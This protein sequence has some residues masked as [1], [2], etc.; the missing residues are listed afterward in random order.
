MTRRVLSVGQCTAD[1]GSIC[2]LLE[3]EFATEVVPSD[4]ARQALA[5]A[6]GERFDLVLVN[7][8]LDRDGSEGL[9]IVRQI[10]TEP[11]L[12]ALPVMLVTNYADHQA[13]AV[14]EGAE[15][16][17]GKSELS[18]PATRSKLARFLAP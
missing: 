5:L 17:F 18:L 12:A 4:D 8:I 15:Q 13:L 16:G 10:K 6:R 11:A 2:R 1:H 3:Q 9:A 7:R 14:A